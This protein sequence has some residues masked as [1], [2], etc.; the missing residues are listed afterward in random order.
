MAA[1]WSM[2]FYNSKDWKEL[3]M[4][5]IIQRGAT[6][7]RCHKDFLFDTS[8]L[9]GHHKKEL[10][11]DTICD[12]TIALNPDNIEIICD[13]CHNKEHKRFGYRGQHQVYIV[14]GPPCSGKSTFVHQMMHRGDLIVNMDLLYRAVSGCGLYD[15]PDNLKQNIFRVQDILIDQIRTR[16]GQWNDAYIEGGYPIKTIREGLAQRVRGEL[17]YCE[18]TK[19][20]CLQGAAKRGVFAKEWEGYIQKWFT[21]YQP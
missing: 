18:A 8:R 19:E 4:M 17:V 9:I 1:S 15:K 11:P 5:L 10:T 7:E 6:C 13:D 21:A 20:E 14:Y 12:P 2:P 16:Y 3:R